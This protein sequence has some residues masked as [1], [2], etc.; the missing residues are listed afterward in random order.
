MTV[1]SI[2]ISV[3]TAAVLGI[4]LAFIISH[5]LINKK[6][7]KIID[8]AYQSILGQKK[9]F[10]FDGKVY[11]LKAEIK[12]GQEGLEPKIDAGSDNIR[13]IKQIRKPIASMIKEE[14]QGKP[15]EKSKKTKSKKPAK[16]GSNK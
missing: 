5:I 7:K 4:V 11:D 9:K 12:K 14:K 15:E 2:L 3:G 8:K 13:K 1:V 10:V 6:K 16:G